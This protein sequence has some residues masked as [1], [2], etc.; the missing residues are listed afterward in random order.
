MA[1]IDIDNRSAKFEVGYGVAIVTDPTWVLQG[2][3]LRVH[4]SIS[5]RAQEPLLSDGT[6]VNA[7]SGSNGVCRNVS[8]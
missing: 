3:G 2:D 4:H 6:A 1:R 7:D 8:A 5:Q